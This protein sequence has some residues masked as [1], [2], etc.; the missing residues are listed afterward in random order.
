MTERLHSIPITRAEAKAFVDLHHR[1]LGAPIQ[2]LFHVACGTDH[3]CG[4]A[5]VETPSARPLVDGW[6]VEVSRCTAIGCCKNVPSY[7]YRTCWRIAREIGY[8]R[9]ITYTG[10]CESGVSLVAAGF[11]IVAEVK[12]RSWDTPSRPRVDKY[13]PQDRLRWE[14]TA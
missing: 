13:E 11:R 7:L 12:G 1:E 5:I 3:I 9:L 8:L 10:K 2:C 6:T 4:V 14:I